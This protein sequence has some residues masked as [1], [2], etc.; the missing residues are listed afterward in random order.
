M[1]GFCL[2]EGKTPLQTREFC[3]PLRARGIRNVCRVLIINTLRLKAGQPLSLLTILFPSIGSCPVLVYFLFLP[4]VS[5]HPSATQA[6][7][8]LK[9]LSL[10]AGQ[11]NT[12][13]TKPF[14]KINSSLTYFSNAS[15]SSHPLPPPP[16]LGVCACVRVCARTHTGWGGALLLPK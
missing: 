15:P 7:E 16:R 3:I 14:F 12:L 6:R 1:S 9:S 5:M 8:V 10:S 2:L 11:L 4:L 13:L